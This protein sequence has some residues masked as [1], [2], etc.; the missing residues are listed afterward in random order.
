M[1][2]VTNFNYI[3]LTSI[4]QAPTCHID[5]IGLYLVAIMMQLQSWIVNHLPY[6]LITHSLLV[7][8]RSSAPAAP[9][10]SENDFAFLSRKPHELVSLAKSNTYRAQ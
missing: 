5:V 2:G 8:L 1:S 3:I 9:N 10:V 4:T 6:N 7:L